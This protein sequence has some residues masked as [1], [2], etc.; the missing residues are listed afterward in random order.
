M[1]V[2]CTSISNLNSPSECLIHYAS[3]TQEFPPCFDRVTSLHFGVLR[4]KDWAGERGKNGPTEDSQKCG[5]LSMIE[6]YCFLELKSFKK[7]KKKNQFILE[8]LII[9]GKS[10]LSGTA[11]AV[12]VSQL[13][14]CVIS[15]VWNWEHEAISLVA[16]VSGK[17]WKLPDNCPEN[18]PLSLCVCLERRILKRKKKS[19]TTNEIKA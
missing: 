16:C 6:A 9:R 14:F 4:T 13:H 17:G 8:E 3:R 18:W 5:T 1:P 15:G 19:Q 7:K 11:S 12:H 2:M 10:V